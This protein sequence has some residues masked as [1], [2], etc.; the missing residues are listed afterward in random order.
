MS[1]A[2]VGVTYKSC[3]IEVREQITL[4][5]SKV[6]EGLQSLKKQGISEVIILSTCNRCE[7]YIEDAQIESAIKK[8]ID[9]FGIQFKHYLIVM[10]DEVAI[11]HLFEVTVGLDSMVLGE[12]QIL[13]QVKKAYQ[14]A[15][16]QGTSSK[17]TH[18]IFR[19]AISLAK[20]IK[21][22][23]KISEYP[24]SI[25]HIAIKFLKE[26]QGTLK[27]KK[28]LIIGLGQMNEI[29]LKYLLEEHLNTIYVTNRTHGKALEMKAIY[30]CITPIN[31]EERYKILEEVDF[32]ISATA[33]PHTILRYEAMPRLT[34]RIDIMDIG[35]PR[36]VDERINQLPNA[37]VYHM[38]DLQ[39]IAKENHTIRGVLSSKA[40]EKVDETVIRLL[41][42]MERLPVEEV[43][44]EIDA[45]CTD[46][47]NYTAKFLDKKI[48]KE[49]STKTLE[50]IVTETVK[51]CM[52]T[53][54]ASLLSIEDIA[55][56]EEYAKVMSELFKVNR[57][58]Q[59]E[60]N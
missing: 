19:E 54:I 32:V 22:E 30:E 53:P 48:S 42:W 10:Q 28:A 57:V 45:Y 12:D 23:M 56:R 7:I 58:E 20:K 16:Q 29:A 3:P 13:G 36:D 38:D 26:K 15:T 9:F 55:K 43:I 40:E 18:K 59:P 31:Y 41:D 8:V 1:F 37:Y 17:I 14:V 47:K 51:R 39:S 6:I 50:F 11:R 4:T 33:S 52:R 44:K 60:R 46:V 35:M 25:S 2:V 5:T 34:K 27:D 21:S 49:V 24:L